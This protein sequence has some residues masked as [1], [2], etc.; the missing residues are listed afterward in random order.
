MGH[1]GA[2]YQR[3]VLMVFVHHPFSAV[4]LV[5]WKGSAPSYQQDPEK[6]TD[7]GRTTF[8]THQPTWGDVK[9]LLDTLI[10]YEDKLLIMAKAREEAGRRHAANLLSPATLVAMPEVDPNWD[11]NMET[12]AVL[13]MGYQELILYGLKNGVPWVVNLAKT[14]EIYQGV[15][16]E[17]TA[18]YH[19][20]LEV[21]RKHTT[22]DPWPW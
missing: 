14:Y 12:G 8:A 10:P 17:P 11:T 9:M 4:E 3:E 16:E 13:L 18:Y 2:K 6:V 21:F 7:L 1:A 5:T 22:L 15:Q 19:Q 20:F